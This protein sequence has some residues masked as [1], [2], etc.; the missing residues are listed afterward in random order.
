MRLIDADDL[1]KLFR[2]VIGAL[3]KEPVLTGSLEHM[4]R[5]SAMVIQMIQDAPSIEVE[6]FR[7]FGKF[8]KATNA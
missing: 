1:E 3:A 6:N 5:A 7:N 4:M 8:D 2:E